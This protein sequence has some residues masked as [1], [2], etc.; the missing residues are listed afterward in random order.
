L[1][2][3]AS[4]VGSLAIPVTVV[5]A[6]VIFRKPLIDLFSRVNSY[7]GLGQKVQFGQKL[8]DAEATVSDAAARAQP[9]E[10]ADSQST[11]GRRHLSSDGEHS[12]NADLVSLG[13]ATVAAANPSFTI[14]KAW[15]ELTG[16]L[17]KLLNELEPNPSGSQKFTNLVFRFGL[18]EERGEVDRS[19]V[20]AV[21]ELFDLRNHVAHGRNN[22]TAGE[23]VAYAES[24]HQLAST[25]VRLTASHRAS[26]DFADHFEVSR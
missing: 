22:P 10:S 1:A 15:E 19:F 13:L 6:L 11:E 26:R 5:T 23:A 25:A 4:V 20:R 16:S 3:I 17:A 21:K 12:E 24:A 8:A 18:L 14:I 2:F 9:K 7:E